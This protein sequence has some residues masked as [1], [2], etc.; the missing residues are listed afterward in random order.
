MATTPLPSELPLFGNVLTLV[1]T[2]PEAI[3]MFP[4]VHGFSSERSRVTGRGAGAGRRPPASAW[5]VP[6]IDDWLR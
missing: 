2:R 1:G 4:I 3:E 5:G 6:P